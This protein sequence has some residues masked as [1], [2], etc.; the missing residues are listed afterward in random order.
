MKEEMKNFIEWLSFTGE[1]E[2][3]IQEGVK[4]WFMDDTGEV[5][6]TEDIYEYYKKI[7]KN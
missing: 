6:T 4:K 2:P 5:M 7:N 1:V 3:C